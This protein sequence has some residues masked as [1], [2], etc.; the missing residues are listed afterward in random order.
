MALSGEPLGLTPGYSGSVRSPR[1]PSIPGYP[2]LTV[3]YPTELQKGGIDIM[4]PVIPPGPGVKMLG[5]Q[6]A[7][8]SYWL[9]LSRLGSCRN[10]HDGSCSEAAPGAVEP[11][12]TSSSNTRER[13]PLGQ[14]RSRFPTGI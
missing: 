4:I 9:S 10:Y 11:Y 1:G 8:T 2:S 6:L 3:G 13:L 14:K 7:A 5:C 12:L